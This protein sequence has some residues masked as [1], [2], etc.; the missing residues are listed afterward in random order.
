MKTEQIARFR[1]SKIRT[2]LIEHHPFW[3]Y[4]FLQTRITA[5][6]SLVAIAATNGIDEIWFNP[7]LIQKLTDEELAFILLHELCHQVFA[8]SHRRCG[9]DLYRWNCATDYAIN[10]MVLGIKSPFDLLTPMYQ[11]P[12]LKDPDF[13]TFS[14]LYDPKY[15]GLTAEQIYEALSVNESA[16]MPNEQQ[17]TNNESKASV[18]KPESSFEDTIAG[19]DVHFKDSV[20]WKDQQYRVHRVSQAAS[21][22]LSAESRGHIPHEAVEV[23]VNEQES[24]QSHVEANLE[25]IILE[26]CLPVEYCRAK[27]NKKYLSY[28]C[29]YP[30][31]RNI[32]KTL[33]VTSLD[34]SASINN[35]D[36][37]KLLS[38]IQRV[39]LHF[40]ETILIIADEEITAVVADEELDEFL[41]KPRLYGRRGTNHWPIFRWIAEQPSRPTCLL[42]L[43]DLN[44]RIPKS[45]PPYPVIWLVPNQTTNRP[46]WGTLITME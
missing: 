7:C 5:D 9:R 32:E 4:L 8:S 18:D 42:A 46:P 37:F 10:R 25:S 29:I 15:D 39:R 2:Q 45:P 17:Q 30:T 34:T 41:K 40:D 36:V 22:W 24:S 38:A 33:L 12:Q 21:Y 35:Q 44:T 3:G 16:T 1:I 28:D 26:A 13:G 20:T 23:R 27:P 6:E 19:F 43:T 14:V 31:A 11:P